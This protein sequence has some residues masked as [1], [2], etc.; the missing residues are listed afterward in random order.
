M[1]DCHD[2]D[3]RYNALHDA[4]RKYGRHLMNCQYQNDGSTCTCGLRDALGETP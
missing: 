2:D 3:E 4:L 1:D